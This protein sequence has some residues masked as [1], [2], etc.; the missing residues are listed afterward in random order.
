MESLTPKTFQ[1]F[2]RMSPHSYHGF[3]HRSGFSFSDSDFGSKIES[4]GQQERFRTKTGKI[5][6]SLSQYLAFQLFS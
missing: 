1:Q 6:G 3:Q 2:T 4:K 5:K